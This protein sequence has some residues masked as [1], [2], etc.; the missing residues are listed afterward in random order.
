M[1]ATVTMSVDVD[2]MKAFKDKVGDGKI[3]PTIESLMKEY[4]NKI[5]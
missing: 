1:K 3:S 5:Q 4:I 2:V